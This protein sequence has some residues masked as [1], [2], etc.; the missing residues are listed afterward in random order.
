M[1]VDSQLEYDDAQ[2]V[3]EQPQQATATEPALPAKEGAIFGVSAFL[4]SYFASLTFVKGVLT[5][6]GSTPDDIAATWKLATWALLSGLGAGIE[7]DGEAVALGQAAGS[8]LLFIAAPF[9]MLVPLVALA[10]VG[11]SMAKYTN[12]ADATEAAKAGAL[13][14]P[15]WLALTVG[16]AFLSGWE[17]EAEVAF[18]LA[19]QDAILFAGV[20]IPAVFAITGG[21]LYSWPDPAEKV[22]AKIDG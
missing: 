17:S 9:L 18:E 15:G 1:A 5:M 8:E 14:V 12:A 3:D 19:T 2:P 21:L 11:Y 6:G 7:A 20:L 16:F 22:L 13:V 4:L 10:A